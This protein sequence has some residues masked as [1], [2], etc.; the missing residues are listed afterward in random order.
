[1][2]ENVKSISQSWTDMKTFFAEVRAEMKKVSFPTREEVTTTTL[3]VIITSVIFAIFLWFSDVVIQF[4]YQR[5][6]G[7]LS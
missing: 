1:L 6:I 4:L 2:E 5:L 7:V 3:V